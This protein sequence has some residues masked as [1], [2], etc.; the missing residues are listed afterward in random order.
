[1]WVS[2]QMVKTKARNWV[3]LYA[4]YASKQLGVSPKRSSW[5]GEWVL[6][7]ARSGGITSKEMEQGLGRLGFA[8][9]DLTWAKPFL[10][11]LYAWTA[12]IR[13]KR[14]C[15]KIPVVL[16]TLLCFLHSGCRKVTAYKTLLRNMGSRITTLNFSGMRGH[17]R[18]CL[19]WWFLAGRIWQHC[20]RVFGGESGEE[21]GGMVVREE[22]PEE[23]NSSSGATGDS[24][25]GGFGRGQVEDQRS[26]LGLA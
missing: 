13:N 8:A 6:S 17:G 26:L 16:G 22:G 15:F 21:L 5:L 9:N 23:D 10:G 4:D 1:M 3:G 12:P 7:V 18:R 14:G 2:I 25:G 20:G 24:G 11:P 19:D